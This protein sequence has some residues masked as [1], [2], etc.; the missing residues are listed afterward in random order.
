MLDTI[1]YVIINYYDKEESMELNTL[2][3]RI[4]EIILI[5]NN[6]TNLEA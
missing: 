1:K 3:D 6:I 4:N 2:V 5:R